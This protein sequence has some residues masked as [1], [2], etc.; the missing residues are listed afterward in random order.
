MSNLG[1]RIA[2]MLYE[3]NDNRWKGLIEKMKTNTPVEEAD[4]SME[5]ELRTEL[6]KLEARINELTHEVH[7]FNEIQRKTHNITDIR[8]AFVE[9]D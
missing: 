1:G 5:Q 7:L 2:G 4:I 9:L 8:S 6:K 3:Q